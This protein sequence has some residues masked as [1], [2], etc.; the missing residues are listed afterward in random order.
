M[1]LR[2]VKGGIRKGN[3]FFVFPRFPTSMASHQPI[4]VSTTKIR[5]A[6]YSTFPATKQ[7]VVVEP[8]KSDVVYE[9]ISPQLAPDFIKQTSWS[10]T[11]RKIFRETSE[12]PYSPDSLV[13]A[14]DEIEKSTRDGNQIRYL[15]KTDEFQASPLPSSTQ[16]VQERP[17][18]AEIRENPVT[19]ENSP[20][21]QV[22]H[23]GTRYFP[24]QSKVRGTV[25]KGF[26]LPARRPSEVREFGAYDIPQS[27]RHRYVR[28]TQSTGGTKS[29]FGGNQKRLP[30]QG[31]L[32]PTN[33]E[34]DRHDS[35]V[36]KKE[37]VY[38]GHE[39]PDCK[40]KSPEP[41]RGSR[42]CGF[43]PRANVKPRKVPVSP[44]QNTIITP[45]PG[46][47]TADVC[48][49]MGALQVNDEMRSILSKF[50]ENQFDS[51][52][53]TVTNVSETSM[54]IQYYWSR[55]V[56]LTDGRKKGAVKVQQLM[57]L[58]SDETDALTQQC[59]KPAIQAIPSECHKHRHT[60]S[61]SS[62]ISDSDKDLLDIVIHK[63]ERGSPLDWPEL[64]LLKNAHCRLVIP[65]ERQLKK[66]KS[67]KNDPESCRNLET[68]IAEDYRSY[69]IILEQIS[70]VDNLYTKLAFD[71]MQAEA[72]WYAAR[73]NS[74][75]I[76]RSNNYRLGLRF[77]ADLL[78]RASVSLDSNDASLTTICEKTS[79]ILKES[80]IVEE[81][82]LKCCLQVVAAA[83]K[84]SKMLP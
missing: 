8:E 29:R 45:V 50:V 66:M 69:Q 34:T 13:S 56:N 75:S 38:F 61:P 73:V 72:Y 55:I 47:E 83:E 22:V 17:V 70:I 53:I 30:V 57:T 82:I 35:F 15:R 2:L 62:Q 40:R 52:D 76:L 65:K 24:I 28:K 77:Y 81:P 43:C 79:L 64:F 60:H 14:K 3:V 74:D 44:S 67:V 26:S 80:G 48:K 9:N 25:E 20:A 5:P 1:L 58:S 32:I 84:V 16:Q 63:I 33:V 49:A 59:H 19:E 37:E 46:K 12:G 39:K 23:P 71:I 54:P 11:Y 68:Q 78:Q 41:K 27:V 6:L 36:D 18:Q 7:A 31:L 10:K 42:K 21:A 4:R 51:C